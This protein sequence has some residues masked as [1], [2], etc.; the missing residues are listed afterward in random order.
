METSGEE[1]WF[2]AFRMQAAHMAFP[3]W[4]PRPDEWVSLY[5]SL[6]GQ[7][8]SVTTEI[9]VYRGNQRIRHRHYS[10]REAR[11]FWLE[12]MERVSQ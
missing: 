7:Q 12:L 8:V 10:G 5:T 4:S 2:Q 9:A 6:V 3:D 1:R 11:E